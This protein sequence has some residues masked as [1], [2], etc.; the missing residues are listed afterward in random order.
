MKKKIIIGVLVMTMFLSFTGCGNNTSESTGEK[1][2][3]IS[4]DTFKNYT[5]LE[6]RDNREYLVYDNDTCVLYI[7]TL[8]HTGSLNYNYSLCPYYVMNE[9]NEPVVGVYNG[10]IPWEEE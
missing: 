10:D 7:L 5:V 4:V 9:N 6:Q 8:Q 2:G 3:N 1:V